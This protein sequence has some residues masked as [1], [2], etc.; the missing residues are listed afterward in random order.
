MQRVTRQRRKAIIF[1][2]STPTQVLVLPPMAASAAKNRMEKRPAW[3]KFTSSVSFGNW[4]QTS[5]PESNNDYCVLNGI[6][7]AQG[8]NYILAKTLQMWRCM[9]AYYR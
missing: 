9:I 1:L 8:P 3:E 4:L 6:A 5:V 7:S 2:Y